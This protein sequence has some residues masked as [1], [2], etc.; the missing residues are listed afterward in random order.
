MGN[1]AFSTKKPEKTAEF[2]SENSS[3][4]S[5]GF[6]PRFFRFFFWRKN[7]RFF[8]RKSRRISKGKFRGKSIR[9]RGFHQWIRMFKW[10][11]HE[12]FAETRYFTIFFRNFLE[13]SFSS[14]VEW[15]GLIVISWE[16]RAFSVFSSDSR[17]SGFEP[18]G[19]FG[20][21]WGGTPESSGYTGIRT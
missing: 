4:K 11:N 13:K 17:F 19:V 6:Y 15:W 14:P 1:F 7:T 9:N 18:S 21:D 12:N 3:R 8:S 10:R 2:S 5:S 16:P 20:F